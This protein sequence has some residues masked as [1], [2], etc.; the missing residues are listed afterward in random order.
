ME[1]EL[2][3]MQERMNRTENVSV[4]E[5]CEIRWQAAVMYAQKSYKVRSEKNNAIAEYNK[6]LSL[7]TASGVWYDMGFTE[8]E[9]I[10]HKVIFTDTILS[11]GGTHAS[12]SDY[13]SV[14]LR[15][16][17]MYPRADQTTNDNAN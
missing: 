9:V 8:N 6:T 13:F 11:K 15:E 5:L 16:N 17:K 4:N 14:L 3:R 7:S 2:K 12:V 1:T 10:E